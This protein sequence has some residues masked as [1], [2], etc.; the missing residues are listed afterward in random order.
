VFFDGS[1]KDISAPKAQQ[2][3]GDVVAQLL[4]RHPLA[5]LTLKPIFVE[6]TSSIAEQLSTKTSIRRCCQQLS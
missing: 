3:D 1:Q 5:S 2:K 4:E 6:G